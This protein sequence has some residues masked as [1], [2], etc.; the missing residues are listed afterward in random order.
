MQ[1]KYFRTILAIIFLTTLIFGGVKI[2]RAATCADDPNPYLYYGI[3]GISKHDANDFQY[4]TAEVLLT[5]LDEYKLYEG[6][7]SK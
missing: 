4:S 2:A 7:G 5:C 6:D 1:K 3:A